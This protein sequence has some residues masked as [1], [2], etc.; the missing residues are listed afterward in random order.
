[1]HL[2]PVLVE[3]QIARIADT[4]RAMIKRLPEDFEV[5]KSSS[6]MNKKKIPKELLVSQPFL[7]N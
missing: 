6:T 2:N 7:T 5:K 3:S 1:M 4:A